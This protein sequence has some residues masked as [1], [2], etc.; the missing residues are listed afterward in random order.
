MYLAVLVPK[1]VD[2]G[3]LGRVEASVKKCLGYSR[4]IELLRLY[5]R[6]RPTRVGAAGA[7]GRAVVVVV[8]ADAEYLVSAAKNIVVN[9]GVV[10]VVSNCITTAV[11]HLK[12]VH[13]LITH[14][15]GVILKRPGGVVVG[16]EKSLVSALCHHIA[17][18]LCTKAANVVGLVFVDS[19]LGL[20]RQGVTPHVSLSVP[21][22][23]NDVVGIDRDKAHVATL[24]VAER[25]CLGLVDLCLK[26]VE[27]EEALVVKLGM[28]N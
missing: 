13:S 2:L 4:I 24:F 18:T 7:I 9:S 14:I 27:R 1:I 3:S 12:G 20:V 6:P 21:A 15:V 19:D 26:A 16:N 17:D 5:G 22:G 23:L 11:E 8:R 28:R 10:V 25:V